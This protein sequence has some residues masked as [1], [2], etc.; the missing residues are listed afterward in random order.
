[1]SFGDTEAALVTSLHND[2]PR[3]VLRRDTKG[4]AKHSMV[5]S[6]ASMGARMWIASR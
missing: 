3:A 1:M 4:L 6:S 5:Y 2:Y